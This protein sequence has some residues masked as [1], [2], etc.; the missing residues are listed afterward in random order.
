[1]SSIY[2]LERVD[3]SDGDWEKRMKAIMEKIEKAIKE[4][5][6]LDPVDAVIESLSLRRYWKY[7]NLGKLKPPAIDTYVGIK[8]PIDHVQMFQSY[9]H[10]LGASDTIICRAFPTIFRMI[11]LDWYATLKPNSIRSFK[12]FSHEF[13][14]YFA[15]SCKHLSF[16]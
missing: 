15:T 13:I 3:L 5:G 6:L 14:F 11:V 8:D 4:K 7:P 9:M 1:M 16:C 10:Y 12:E 2:R